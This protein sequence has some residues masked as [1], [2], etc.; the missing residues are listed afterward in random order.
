VEDVTGRFCTGQLWD[1]R[2]RTTDDCDQRHIESG[3]RSGR[4]KFG[5]DNV[6]SSRL[7]QERAYHSWL[8]R[9]CSLMDRR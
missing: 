4:A 3:R 8:P 2:D 9:Y 5:S 1:P 6:T 7:S